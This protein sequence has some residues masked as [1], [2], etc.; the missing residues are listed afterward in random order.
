MS[1]QCDLRSMIEEFKVLVVSTVIP[2]GC[3]RNQVSPNFISEPEDR[4]V[5]ASIFLT[6]KTVIEYPSGSDW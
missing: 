1:L 6:V 5:F 3:N 2:R 4:F